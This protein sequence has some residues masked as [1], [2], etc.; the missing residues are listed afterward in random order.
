M[1]ILI[2][3]ECIV[4]SACE[5]ECPNNAIYSE[6]STWTW[7]GGTTLTEIQL[8]DGTI[9]DGKALQAPLSEQFYFIVS[10]KCTE[11]TGFHEEPA[12]NLVCPVSCCVPDPD[13]IESKEEL[14]AKKEWLH[15]S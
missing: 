6:G 12:C 5:P 8:E 9:V 3:D 10:G 4:C 15:A 2:T 11:C 7:G 1:A 13:V 14:L